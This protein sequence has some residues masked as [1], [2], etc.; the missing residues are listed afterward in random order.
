MPEFSSVAPEN[1]LKPDP[2]RLAFEI[3]VLSER[4]TRISGLLKTVFGG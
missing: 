4:L 3:R 1:D 2:A